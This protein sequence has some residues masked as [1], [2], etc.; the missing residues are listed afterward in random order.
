MII[1]FCKQFNANL[2]D[3][4]GK[5]S[6]TVAKGLNVVCHANAVNEPLMFEMFE[7]DT[8]Y[9]WLPITEHANVQYRPSNSLTYK[10]INASIQLFAHAFI[11]LIEIIGYIHL[12]LVHRVEF[13]RLNYQ[14]PIDNE[15]YNFVAVRLS[16]S[17]RFPFRSN[18][19]A[20]HQ[21]CVHA[22]M[23]KFYYQQHQPIEPLVRRYALLI[24]PIVDMFFLHVL[25]YALLDTVPHHVHS[26]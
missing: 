5:G 21:F 2:P 1:K 25:M 12:S 22:P 4:L 18:V 6:I 24:Q 17:F 8:I 14:Q 16:D 10:K 7:V 19:F 15:L 20:I 23:H 11:Y 26:L 3:G 9:D 13:Y